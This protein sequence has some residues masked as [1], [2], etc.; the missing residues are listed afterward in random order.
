MCVV[1]FHSISH[2][3]VQ[4]PHSI[5]Y[6]FAIFLCIAKLFKFDKHRQDEV[7]VRLVD[8][9]LTAKDDIFSRKDIEKLSLRRKG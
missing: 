8:A 5:V 7:E 3:I 6:F 2:S 1:H 4:L 9:Y